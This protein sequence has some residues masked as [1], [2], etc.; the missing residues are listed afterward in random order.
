MSL[1][2]TSLERE[3]GMSGMAGMFAQHHICV[4]STIFA[5]WV[6]TLGASQSVVATTKHSVVLPTI[7]H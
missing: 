1:L 6:D 7:K 2:F 4:H 3:R 5:Q